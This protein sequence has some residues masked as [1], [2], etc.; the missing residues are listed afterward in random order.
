MYGLGHN[1]QRA[2]Y[3]ILV[4]AVEKLFEKHSIMGL[5][6]SSALFKITKLLPK[7]G[8]SSH[9]FPSNIQECPFAL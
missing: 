3:L 9:T 2:S 8:L 7:M 4:V 1:I 5:V 6:L